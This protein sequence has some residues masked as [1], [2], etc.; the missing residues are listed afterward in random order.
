[1][2]EFLLGFMLGF[3]LGIG[4][5]TEWLKVH[6]RF[7]E[8]PCKSF[9]CLLWPQYSVSRAKNSYSYVFR[10]GARFGILR[11]V[12]KVVGDE[13]SC[14]LQSWLDL[15]DLLPMHCFCTA[16][17]LLWSLH[18]IHM[19]VTILYVKFQAGWERQGSGLRHK[20][21]GCV[22]RPKSLVLPT[23]IQLSIAQ[24]TLDGFT[25]SVAL[26]NHHATSKVR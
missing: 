13:I 26:Y 14:M 5:G 7:R 21:I 6:Q 8:N 9:P 11:I 3:M 23:C 20:R 19:C 10:H 17:Q 1:M 24:P 16:P 12:K 18:T 4:L 22:F 2:L 25:P 15:D